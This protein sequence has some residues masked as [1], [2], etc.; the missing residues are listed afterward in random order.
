MD[1]EECFFG[2]YGL[3]PWSKDGRRHL[4]HRRREGRAAIE[5]CVH[6]AVSGTVT[7]LAETRAWNYQQ[8][9]MTQWLDLDG[10]ESVVFNDVIGR[11]LGCRM[12]GADGRETALNWPIQAL[13]PGTAE[14]ISLNYRRLAQL[15]PEYGYHVEVDNFAP[16]QVLE[17]DGLWCLR[18]DTGQAQLCVSLRELAEAA[19]AA[20]TGDRHKVNHVVY[21]PRG[22]QFAFLHR[23]LGPRGKFSRLYVAKADGTNLRLLLDHR[24]V[25]HVA[26]RDDATLLA[27]ARAPERGDRYYLID[28]STGSYEV[29][30]EGTLDR[31]GD[32]H[33]SY[34][35]DRRWVVTDSYPD[36]SRMSRLIL[37]N[38]DNGRVVEVGAFHSP[39]RFDGPNRCD[40][41]PRWSPSGT[42]ISIDSVHEG[43]RGIYAI[44]VRKLLAEGS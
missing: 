41:H 19:P 34:S 16:D 2:Y 4:L 44:N 13:R 6:D 31:F 37:C 7:V 42:E 36:R 5:I 27:Y 39:L 30:G 38:V 15:R 14:A 29:L 3:Q 26:W 33:P 1:G 22:G 43:R 18:L 23:W 9:A 8:G 20:M 25:S 28:V 35:P 11:Q 17:S 24:M 32:G 10:V 40:L 21:S 12:I